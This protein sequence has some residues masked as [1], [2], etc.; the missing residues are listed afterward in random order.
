[1]FSFKAAFNSSPKPVYN[2]KMNFAFDDYELRFQCMVK[3]K[4]KFINLITIKPRYSYD[5][6]EC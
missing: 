3:V 5:F 2:A 6:E 1:M 4:R